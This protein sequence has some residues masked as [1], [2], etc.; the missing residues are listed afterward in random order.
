M[1]PHRLRCLDC[2]RRAAPTLDLECHECGGLFAV[3]YDSPPV[4]GVRQPVEPWSLGQGS[5][6]TFAVEWPLDVELEVKLEFLAP[7]GSFKDRGA[8]T[9]IGVA[10]E[11][12]V[13]EFVEDSSGNAGAALSAFG[14]SAEMTAHIFLPATASAGKRSQVEAVGGVVHPI[15]GPRAASAEAAAS[16]AG[17]TG[18]PFLSHNRSPYFSEGMKIAAAEIAA[19]GLPDSIVLPVGNGSLLI[20][21]WRGFTELAELGATD[22]LPKLHA[23]QSSA[24]SPLIAAFR[25]HD[26]G[27]TSA[28]ASTVAEG[29]A[30]TDP[31]RKTEMLAALHASGGTAVAV[32]EAEIRAAHE[33]IGRRGLYVEPTAAVSLAGLERL[34]VNGVIEAG[35]R[36]LAPLTGSGLKGPPIR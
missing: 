1:T 20:G 30:V 36:V 23:V 34:R 14:A 27:R 10:R 8:A 6:P 21:L 15:A 31:P 28:T 9:L 7:T 33:Q 16:F 5:T 19:H 25:G 18:L 12:A 22:R 26:F 11:F 2:G 3:E 35:E 24:V 4:G 17:Q 32:S 29:I 13:S